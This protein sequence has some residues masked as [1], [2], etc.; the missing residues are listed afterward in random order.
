MT[1]ITITTIAEPKACIFLGRR[2]ILVENAPET[3]EKL[4]GDPKGYCRP[5]K[6][7]ASIP[8][9]DARSYD[10]ENERKNQ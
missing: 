6:I 5:T 8:L 1:A 9:H 10:R 3:A 7:P 2:R 4:A